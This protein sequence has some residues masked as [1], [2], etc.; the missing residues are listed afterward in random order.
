LNKALIGIVSALVFLFIQAVISS[1]NTKATYEFS[2]N[3]NIEDTLKLTLNDGHVS[4]LMSNSRKTYYSSRFD[5]VFLRFQNHYYLFGIEHID[6]NNPQLTF[7]NFFI[8]S[9]RSGDAIYIS[10]S[11]SFYQSNDSSDV[12]LGKRIIN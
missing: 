9:L 7:S 1:V 3:N 2:T 4:M 8:D 5:G 12:L 6:N 10:R 11:P